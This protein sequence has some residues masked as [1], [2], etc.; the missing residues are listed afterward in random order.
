MQHLYLSRQTNQRSDLQWGFRQWRHVSVR[1]FCLFYST[2][3]CSQSTV[4]V[5][6]EFH[7]NNYQSSIAKDHQPNTR[8]ELKA[9]CQRISNS[10]VGSHK[11]FDFY[12]RFRLWT[13]QRL[14]LPNNWMIVFYSLRLCT[15]QYSTVRL[16]PYWRRTLC[17]SRG[18]VWFEPQR[19]DILHR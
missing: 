6:E 1:R 18:L 13:L 15:V 7:I 12:Q 19:K 17:L 11:V 16:Y 9:E 10:N 3:P 5:W 2:L 14:E 8:L 4:Q